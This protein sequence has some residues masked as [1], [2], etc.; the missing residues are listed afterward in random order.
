MEHIIFWAVVYFAAG[1]LTGQFHLLRCPS[2]SSQFSGW[3]HH[4]KYIAACA[5]VSVPMT[6][7]GFVDYWLGPCED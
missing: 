6:V 7:V 3:S 1:A 4:A 5:L 2:C